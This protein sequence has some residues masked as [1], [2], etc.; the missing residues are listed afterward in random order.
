MHRC[1]M[2]GVACCRWLRQQH[3]SRCSPPWWDSSHREK[4]DWNICRDPRLRLA[5][6]TTGPSVSPGDRHTVSGRPVWPT[7]RPTRCPWLVKLAVWLVGAGA[8]PAA[9]ALLKGELGSGKPS[10]FKGLAPP[11]IEEPVT[12]RASPSPSTTAAAARARIPH[13]VHL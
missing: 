6:G 8:T 9:A 7:L 10:C 12:S 3:Q 11:G 2:L 4:V 5:L 13:L 1:C